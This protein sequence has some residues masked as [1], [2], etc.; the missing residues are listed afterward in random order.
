MFENTAATAGAAAIVTFWKEAGPELW[1]AKRPDFDHRFREQFLDLH[2]EAARR[3]LSR[4]L[5]FP[6]GALA[7]CL[8][9]DQFP[10]NAFRGTPHMYATDEVAL[11]VADAAVR[12]G[13]DRALDP[14]L[15]LFVYLP[16]GHSERLDDQNRSVELAQRLGSDS[17]AHAVGHRAIVERFG[18]FPHRNPILGRVMLPAEQRFLDEGGFA[19]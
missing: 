13:H 12:A 9:L 19:G 1:F 5:E 6:E 7:L 3:K 8:L 2:L 10:R 4:L 14:A 17:V 11:E 15:A 18:R 16:F